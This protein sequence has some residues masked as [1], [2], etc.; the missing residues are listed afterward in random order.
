MTRVKICGI[1]TAS[2]RDICLNSGVDLL[3]FNIYKKSQRYVKIKK[4]KKM[5]Y[6]QIRKISVI[7]GVNNTVSQWDETI[8][9][10]NPGYIQLHGDEDVDFVRELKELH[11]ETKII[12]KVT[13]EQKKDFKKILKACDYILCDTACSDYGGSGKKFN[14]K[15]LGDIEGSIKKRLIAAG[16]INQYNV[17]KILRYNIF[18][19]DVASGSE[20]TQGKKDKQKI[21][22]IVSRVR[23]YEK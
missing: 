19:V 1:K 17:D 7:V 6:P 8:K 14:W 9:I 21:N 10:I 11:P 16:G 13:I 15:K 20:D 12:K 22:K 5:V 2:D 4:I 3:G 23:E 18:G